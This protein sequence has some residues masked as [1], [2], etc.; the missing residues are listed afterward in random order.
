MD[1]SA[2]LD[3][4]LK[5]I[6]E[7]LQPEAVWLFG[8]RAEGR[9]RADSDYDL[10]VVLADES[11][12]AELDAVAAYQIV[13]GMGLAVDLVPCTRSIFEEEKHEVNTLPRA[14]F[15]RGKLLYEQR[16]PSRNAA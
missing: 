6:V 16:T 15:L 7:A 12:A 5:K 3:R 8:S 10:L 14:A 4:V 1:D 2:K 11:P 13:R 9:A